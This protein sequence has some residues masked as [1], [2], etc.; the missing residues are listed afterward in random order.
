M[1]SSFAIRFKSPLYLSL[2]L[3]FLG[4]AI[5]SFLLP[6]SEDASEDGE[7]VVASD[8]EALSNFD[9]VEEIQEAVDRKDYEAAIDMAEAGIDTFPEDSAAMENWR[10]AAMSADGFNNSPLGLAYQFTSGFVTGNPDGGAS[11]AGSVVSDFFLWGDIRDLTKE[12][13][14]SDDPDPLIVALSAAGVATQVLP[15]L[16]GPISLTKTMKKVSALSKPMTDFLMKQ[17]DRIKS[18][19]P[20]K[21]AQEL[22]GLLTPMYDLAK[23]SKSFSQAKLFLKACKDSDTVKFLATLGAK[24]KAKLNDLGQVMTVIGPKNAALAQDAMEYVKKTGGQGI[25]ALKKGMKKGRRGIEMVL[26]NPQ[27]VKYGTRT[28]KIASKYVPKFWKGLMK[29]MPHVIKWLRMLMTALSSALSAWFVALFAR[30]RVSARTIIRNRQKQDNDNRNRTN[31]ESGHPSSSSVQLDAPQSTLDPA[32]SAIFNSDLLSS[33]KGLFI[34]S[35]GIFLCVFLFMLIDPMM[36]STTPSSFGINPVLGNSGS[37]M[38]ATFMILFILVLFVAF[39]FFVRSMIRI[40]TLAILHDQRLDRKRKLLLL[41]NMDIWFDV[42]LYGGL[43]MTIFA[44]IL[45]CLTGA[46]DARYLA[47]IATFLGILATIFL[48][49]KYLHNI[50]RFL[51]TGSDSIGD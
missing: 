51:L 13:V 27:V 3:I 26:K 19:P 18:L 14:L 38:A 23:Q 47:Y 43:A 2:A 33:R 44:F 21:M 42:P 24:S 34:L 5:Y 46:T 12:L 31:T 22:M 15:P 39:L 35:G 1:P 30:D 8:F 10:N 4:C 45:I 11:T 6:T 28:L 9:F 50:R 49:I 20:Q 36:A 40:K 25:D 41:D 7:I 32:I 16:D 17:M 29:T 48:R 37:S